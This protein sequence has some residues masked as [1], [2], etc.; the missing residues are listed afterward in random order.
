MARV[1]PFSVNSQEALA[2]EAEVHRTYVSML[3]RGQANPSLSVIAALAAA[4]E[5][6]V[7]S[8]FREA[9]VPL[10]LPTEEPEDRYFFTN[11]VLCMKPGGRSDRPRQARTTP[12][13]PLPRVGEKC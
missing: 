7:T 11:A 8:L 10:S 12:S 5:T 13:P 4:L 9:G 1:R 2:D 3:E 6:S